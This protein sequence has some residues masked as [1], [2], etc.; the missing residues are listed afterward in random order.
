MKIAAPALFLLAGWL[1]AVGGCLALPDGG[2]IECQ[3]NADCDSAHGEV[4]AE[5]VCWGNPPAGPF[6]AVVSPPAELGSDLVT[7][8]L[9][10]LVVPED[11]WLGDIAL[12]DAVSYSGALVPECATPLD[13]S[14]ARGATITI[15]RPSQFQGGPGVSLSTQ[16]DPRTGAFELVVP[17]T[18]L[19]DPPF[20]VTVVPNGRGAEYPG[21]PTAG[22]LVPPMRTMLA[23]SGNAANQRLEIGGTSLLQITGSIIDSVTANGPQKY[24]VVALG[25]WDLESRP[26]EVSTVHYTGSD[27][28]YALRISDNV[29]GPVEIVARPYDTNAHLP[30]LHLANVSPGTTDRRLVVPSSIGVP[31]GVDFTVLG[32]DTGGQVAPVAGARVIVSG[33]VPAG[34]PGATSATLLV[35]GTT[36][37][38]GMVKLFVLDGGAIQASYRVSVI[39]P[40][41]AIV[42]V[43]YDKPMMTIAGEAADEMSIRLPDRIALRGVVQDLYGNPLEDVAVTARPALRFTWNLEAAPQTFLSTVP[44]ATA[45][46]PNTGEYVVWVDPFVTDVWGF[47]DLAFEPPGT[48]TKISYAPNLSLHDIEIPRDG[49][50]T[51]VTLPE[52]R[53]PDAS[54]VHGRV[55]DAAGNAIEG[56]ELKIYRID[57][58]LELC[59][60]VRYEPKSCPIPAVLLG[61]GATDADGMARLTLAR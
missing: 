15:T 59:S 49:G 24:R 22:Q 6:A 42:G 50:Q 17:R 21:A 10:N 55:T 20:E 45:V 1:S 11:G 25:H 9:A 46:T 61:R 34:S 27:G 30:T 7:L 43:V 51:T 16:T 2:E 57:T 18:R 58:S 52:I 26:V 41:G 28:T 14:M 31:H 36:G 53:L 3:T 44:A 37:V 4:C 23:I 32:V 5:N 54:H 39:P 60:Q 47:Y 29:V 8:E 48:N 19:T 40:P 13:C 12:E 35:E 56:A 38:D 33:I